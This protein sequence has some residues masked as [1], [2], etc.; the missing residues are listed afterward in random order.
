MCNLCFIG[1]KLQ[2]SHRISLIIRLIDQPSNVRELAADVKTPS[3]IESKNT[4]LARAKPKL[5]VLFKAQE[6]FIR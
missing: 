3:A 1:S 5:T 4:P 2:V 6:L